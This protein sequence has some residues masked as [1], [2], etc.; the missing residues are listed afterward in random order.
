MRRRPMIADRQVRAPM[1]RRATPAIWVRSASEGP[2]KI[3]TTSPAMM[4]TM[5]RMIR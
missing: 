1:M 4:D 2:G 3:A 5:P